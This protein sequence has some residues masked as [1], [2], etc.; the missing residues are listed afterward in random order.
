MQ[1]SSHISNFHISRGGCHPSSTARQLATRKG[2]NSS[3]S[4]IRPDLLAEETYP[5]ARGARSAQRGKVPQQDQTTYGKSRARRPPAEQSHIIRF[6][7]GKP[8]PQF[9][10]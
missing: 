3:T 8:Y 7:C 10:T 5:F 4:R 2:L 1:M 9:L 6:I